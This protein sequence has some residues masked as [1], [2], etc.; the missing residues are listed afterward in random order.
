VSEQYPISELD[1]DVVIRNAVERELTCWSTDMRLYCAHDLLDV[2]SLSWRRIWRLQVALTK[3]GLSLRP[4]RMVELDIQPWRK[5][6]DYQHQVMIE[7][8]W[9]KGHGSSRELALPADP[10]RV[11]LILEKKLEEYGA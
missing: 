6:P 3:I 5:T 11:T 10:E 2:R 7:G 9:W 4:C 1:C 8:R